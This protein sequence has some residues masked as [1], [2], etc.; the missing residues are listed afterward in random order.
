MSSTFPEEGM[1]LADLEVVVAREG[2]QARDQRHRRGVRFEPARRNG[3]GI[4]T[5]LARA[6]ETVTL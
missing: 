1:T 2:A 3:T 5:H 6:R 4:A